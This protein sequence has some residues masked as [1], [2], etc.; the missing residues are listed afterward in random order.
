DERGFLGPPQQL[1]NLTYSLADAPPEALGLDSSNAAAL[2]STDAAFD[3]TVQS[4]LTRP[5][6][7]EKLAQFFIAWL[8]IKDADDL[9]VGSELPEFTPEVANA[10]IDEVRLFLD[11]Q[12]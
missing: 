9:V 6:I 11:R 8:E 5:E 4:I 12:L 3:D 1:Q 10:V 2:V 7:R